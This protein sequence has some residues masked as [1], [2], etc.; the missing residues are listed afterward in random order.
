MPAAWWLRARDCRRRPRRD[1]QLTPLAPLF[2]L[3]SQ[4]HALKKRALVARVRSLVEY[5]GL[6]AADAFHV[7]DADSSG[8]L[9]SSE[10][11]SAFEWLGL[12][13]PPAEIHELVRSTK[14][15]THE[16]KRESGHPDSA[17]RERDQGLG[18]SARWWL[19]D[20][21]KASSGR[22]KR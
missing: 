17:Q 7:F 5:K 2:T 9:S 21:T 3:A 4:Y 20:L 18:K 12:A 14:S 13:L 16:R 11:A 1:W 10:L 22:R 8:T 6:Y 15:I 19:S